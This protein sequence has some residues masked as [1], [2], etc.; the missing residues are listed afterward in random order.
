MKAL[1]PFF[2]KLKGDVMTDGPEPYQSTCCKCGKAI[3]VPWQC[4]HPWCR[5]RG[6]KGYVEDM[7]KKCHDLYNHSGGE[8]LPNNGIRY[9]REGQRY[10]RRHTDS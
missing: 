10:G 4:G 9:Q 5:R 2:D 8:H 3:F 7:C 1:L 6:L